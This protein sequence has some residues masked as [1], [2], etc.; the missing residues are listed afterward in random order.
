MILLYDEFN[1]LD[2]LKEET[3]IELIQLNDLPKCEV[4]EKEN[5]KKNKTHMI[6]F[7]MANGFFRKYL[8][9]ESSI[10]NIEY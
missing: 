5:F 10:R 3:I 4:G 7:L 9:H 6:N 1:I 8:Y 2:K